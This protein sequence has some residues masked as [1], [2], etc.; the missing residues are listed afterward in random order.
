MLNSWQRQRRRIRG[1]WERFWFSRV[2][3]TL[4]G[5][6]RI[7]TG[8]MLL[9]TH[10]IWGLRLHD[11]FG[12][13]SWITPELVQQLQEGQFAL[14]YLWWINDDWLAATHLLAF[15]VLLA[16]TCGLFT[17]I[18]SVL[19]FAILVSY[20]NRAP[21][22]LFGLDQ[23]NAMLTLYLAI[24][25]LTT[26]AE[27]RALSLD[28]WRWARRH[29]AHSMFPDM[30]HGPPPSAGANFTLRLIQV[31]MCVIYFFA[32]ISKLR[33]DAWWNGEAMWLAFSNE[34][35]QS[36]N[37]LWTAGHP[38]LLS[39]MAH[40]TVLWEVSFPFLIWR[41]RWRPLM[42][43]VG[44][45]LHLGIGAFLG[46]WTFG[47]IMIIG[48]AS[49]VP[50]SLVA[51]VAKRWIGKR[52]DDASASEAMPDEST[53]FAEHLAAD[54][55]DTECRDIPRSFAKREECVLVRSV[56]TAPSQREGV[57]N[58]STNDSIVSRQRHPK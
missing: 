54:A 36:I 41:P 4:V 32:G 15:L 20:A 12:S 11:F 57:N 3:P 18:T 9:Y 31:H 7:L 29:A 6:L 24:G 27:S 48:Y 16:F 43:L 45:L 5:V 56:A 23:I 44:C 40:T 30:L 19:T 47:L 33:G 38:W 17:R 52:L 25:Y 58:V 49:F 50:T 21:A 55:T 53:R 22:A 1:E 13:H 39:I 28:R 35:Y 2:D 42:L 51:S 37:M 34:E 14:S 10:A 26:A 46:M 8:L